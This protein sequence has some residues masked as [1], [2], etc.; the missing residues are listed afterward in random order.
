[1]R[2]ILN[3]HICSSY[4][5]PL[6][7][8][9]LISLIHNKLIH[10]SYQITQ[11]LFTPMRLTLNEHIHI[12][13]QPPVGTFHSDMPYTSHT[14]SNYISKPPLVLFTAT[15]LILPI[16]T[17]QFKHAGVPF[18]HCCVTSRTL[19]GVSCLSRSHAVHPLTIAPRRAAPAFF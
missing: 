1:M 15:R 19:R 5:T 10:T 11:G 16:P 4:R 13:Y 3:K 14:H 8:F 17:L 6:V 7:P 18:P 2:P 9:T 12:S